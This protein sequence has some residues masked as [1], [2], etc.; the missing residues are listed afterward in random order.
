[1]AFDDNYYGDLAERTDCAG[2]GDGQASNEEYFGN[3][4]KDNAE[5]PYGDPAV[6]S[7][8]L[9]NQNKDATAE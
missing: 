1:M 2:Y 3:W 5:Q 8:Y 9:A 7:D 4:Q 6:K